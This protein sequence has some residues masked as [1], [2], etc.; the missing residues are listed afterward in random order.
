V[1]LKIKN[2]K[3][4]NCTLCHA[5]LPGLL[6][7]ALS[8][9][10]TSAKAEL[11]T[12]G[13]FESTTNGTGQLGF[14]T[15]VTGWSVAPPDGSYAFVFAPGTADT[16]GAAT[17]FGGDNLQLWGPGNDSP[18]NNGLG[19]SPDGGNYVALDGAFHPGPISQTI[20]GLTAGHQYT[21][22]FYWAAAQQFTF[23][24]DTTEQFQVSLGGDTQTT[25][26]ITDASH[27]FSGWQQ[28]TFTFTADASSDVL[29]F[30]ALGTPSGVPP[31]ALLDGVS[32]NAATPEVGS[33]VMTFT[34][35]AF[36]LALGR[37]RAKS[38]FKS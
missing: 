2:I 30:L 26:I 3:S 21:L 14:N 36:V 4:L 15:D 32:L 18:N 33:W 34:I 29:S 35:L 17:Q 31:F 24:G 12:N 25:A 23:T 20:N 27:G 13:G 6:A 22:S 7:L 5:A 10:A 11:V 38:P 37:L 1:N 16:S 8:T 19:V 28:Q 9:F